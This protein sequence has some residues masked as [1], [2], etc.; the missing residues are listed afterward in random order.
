M[1][2]TLSLGTTLHKTRF[3]TTEQVSTYCWQYV[4]ILTELTVEHTSP[5]FQELSRENGN[6]YGI[7]QLTITILSKYAFTD[8]MD[9]NVNCI[10][11]K[12]GRCTYNVLLES[13]RI[14]IVVVARQ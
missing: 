8:I 7:L 1:L 4:I 12:Y 3:H 5:R 9:A 2:V 13:V 11:K 6:L 14:T 10:V